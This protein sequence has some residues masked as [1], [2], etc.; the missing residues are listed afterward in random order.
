MAITLRN[1]VWIAMAVSAI[2][3]SSSAADPQWYVKKGTWVETMLSARS[4]LEAA[5]AAQQTAN[6]AAGGLLKPADVSLGPWYSIGPWTGKNHDIFF[7]ALPPEKGV[8]LDKPAGNLRWTKRADFRD[9]VKNDLPNGAN[10]I[11]YVYRTISAKAD[12]V[13]QVHLSADD[14]IA[15]FLNG[16]KV[17]ESADFLGIAVARPPTLLA[18]KKGINNLLLKVHD[19]GGYFGFGFSLTP[20]G[21]PGKAPEAAELIW[22]FLQ[23]DFP[24]DAAEMTRERQDKIWD[25]APADASLAQLAAVYAAQIRLPSLAGQAKQQA[26]AVKDVATLQALR[27]SYHRARQVETAMADVKDF[28]FRAVRMAVEDLMRSYG[29]RYPDGPKYLV[30]LDELEKALQAAVPEKGPVNADAAAKVG[31][32]LAALRRQALLANPLLDFEKLMVI[33]RSGNLGLVA[34]YLS[35]SSISPTGFDNEIAVL[36]DLR[37]EPK[38]TTLFQPANKRFVGDVDLHWDAARMLVSMQAKNGRWGVHE[39]S[40]DGKTA[41]ELPLIEQPD[42]DNYDA[43]YLPNGNVIFCST[44]PFTGV[45][46]VGGS[47]HVCNLYLL[48]QPSGRIRRLTFDQEHNWCPVVLNNGR[49]MYLRWEYSDIPHYVARIL[50]HMN[51]D[52][53]EQMEYYGSNSYWPNSTFYARPVPEHPTRFVGIIG[54]HHDVPRMGEL[55]L[56]DL[57]LGR[58]EADGVVQRLPGYGKKVEP[59]ILDG[60]VGASWPKFLH[61]WPLSDKYMLAACQP[62]PKH[63][64][65]LYLVDVFDNLLCLYEKPGSAIFEPIPLVPRKTPPIVPDKVK[66]DRTDALV[67]MNDVYVG[68]GLAGVPRGTIKSLRLFTYHF[69]YHG[70]G[71]QPNRVGLDG[72]WDV[73]RT[74]GTVPVEA[75]GSAF[76]RVPA[77]MPIAVQP[78]DADGKALQIM[79]SW[80]TAM[81]GEVLSCVGCHESQNTPVPNGRSIAAVREPSEI[82]PW[83]G[84][85]RGFSFE[86]EVQPVLNKYCVGCHDSKARPG[87]PD[88][89]AREWVHPQAKSAGYNNGQKFPP[90][91]IALKSY[92]RNPTIESDSHMLTPMDYHA[93]T[94]Y[95]VQMLRKGHHGVKVSPED[96]ERF[97]TWID[98]N[99]PAHGTW[100]EIVGDKKVDHQRDRRLEMMKRYAGV[101]HDPE[102]LPKPAD[103]GPPVAPAP[104]PPAVML[105]K[106]ECPG[107]PFDAAK[108]RQLQEQAGPAGKEI[109]LGEGVKLQL[110][111]IPAGEF[112]MGDSAAPWSDERPAA[113]V[114]IEK[115]FWMGKLEI[116]NQ[117]Y[118]LFDPLHDSRLES[119]DFLQ[120]SVQ[121]R[122]YPLNRPLQP[123]CRVNWRQALAFCRWLSAR[124]GLHVSLP[125]EAQWEWACRAGTDTP[126]WYGNLDTDFTPSANLADKTL[127]QVDRFGWGLPDGA[128][129]PWRLADDR[130]DDKHK[131]AADVGSFAPNPW[132]LLDMHGNVAEWTLTTYKPYPYVDADGRNA[133]DNL[134]PQVRKVVRGGS[135]YTR[136]KNARSSWRLDFYSYHRMY[137]VGF[138]IVVADDGGRVAAK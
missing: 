99:T 69:A 77:N 82:T 63:A 40:I 12:G 116:T 67:Y 128:V 37:G 96:M 23:R 93:D 39:V 21:R 119:G 91:Y 86:R 108:A 35:N 137:D 88:L 71:G 59:I 24:A 66:L 130:F 105:A 5:R 41:R 22:P 73:K 131:V 110:V 135:W 117:Q 123:V 15:A 68:G 18:L 9:G 85:S 78:L 102:A 100:R 56:F 64:W 38:L 50:F 75:D 57:A 106:V 104:A 81:P 48:D 80:F 49:V 133:V 120:F 47:S 70:M 58:K 111:R 44:A 72:P 10:R 28:N 127:R 122:G 114:K 84:P 4:A 16:A 124:T 31:A 42:V 132:G 126:L 51:P 129:P 89:T 109:D 3:V 98:L 34:N 121:E 138:R 62:S 103:L 65:G 11:F 17:W 45:P 136:P 61:P 29:A 90:S 101:D 46:C 19:R 107:W 74:V 30:R 43:C 94:T 134:D 36:T 87:M 55:I 118:A 26:A 8:E 95:L 92:V 25:A 54:G 2:V 112:V 27:A 14:R 113:R 60:L 52:G 83:H 6:A 53:T 76:F 1:R 7:E 33:R 125:S 115:P 32:D 20:T 97:Y 79:R 13:L